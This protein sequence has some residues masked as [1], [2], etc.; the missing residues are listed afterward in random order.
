[1]RKR[2]GIYY[3]VYPCVFRNGRPTCLA[4]A[5]SKSPLGPFQYRGI[6]IDNAKCDPESWNIHGSIEEFHGQWYVFYHRSSGN[7]R[8]NRR[9]CVEKI[10]FNDDGTIG[11]VK[12][13]SQGAGDPFALGEQI[14]G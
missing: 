11:E 4:Y 3:Y 2:N 7:C 8:A 10:F 6:I 14:E 12:M 1:M 5:T 13:T 9:L